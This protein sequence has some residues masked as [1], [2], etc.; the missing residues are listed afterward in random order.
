VVEPR[1][2]GDYAAGFATRRGPTVAVAIVCLA[3]ALRLPG[4]FGWW[5]NP[6]EGTYYAVLTQRSLS[7][8]WAEAFATAHP[9]LYFLILR[10]MGVI[11]TDF[12]WL[13]SLALVSGCAAVYVFVLVGRE[14]AGEGARGWLTGLAAGLLLALSPRA[15]A[16]S[17]VIRPYMLLVLLLAFTL[18]V[19]LRYFRRPSSGLLVW[20]AVSATLSAF[21]HYS[22]ALGLGVIGA[23][24][25]ADGLA[26]GS[27]RPEWRRLLAVQVFPVAAVGVLY[28]THLRQL[29]ES[30]VAEF[31]L[32]G[33]LSGYLIHTPRDAWLSL[34][35]FHSLLVGDWAAV[36]ATLLSLIAVGYAARS[37][38]WAPLVTVASG[39][40]I[41]ML[42]ASLQLYPFGSGRHSAWLVPFVTPGL[43]WII[44]KLATSDRMS[45]TLG[46]LT[47]AAIAAGVLLRSPLG[48]DLT[49]PAAREHVL[50]EEHVAAMAEV[51]D[52]RSEPRVVV[53][54]LET[55]RL[56]VPLYALERQRAQVSPDR[57]LAHFRWASRDV[58]VL[59]GLDIAVR[60]D[61]MDQPNHLY[62]A[63][64]RAASGFGVALP[65]N[66]E[67]VLVLSGGWQ[68]Q[69]IFEL[70]EM[71]RRVGLRGT[72]QSVPGLIALTLDLEAYGR[73]L[74]DLNP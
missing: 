53:M 28:V 69:G 62:T 25:L 32:T 47:V 21:V 36:S 12:A 46:T 65:E 44:A 3:L 57:F 60:P 55:Y 71:S 6:D 1:S 15:I 17:Q 29:M 9:P 54:S 10:G 7:A 56:L 51:L 30:P 20:C 16:L 50:R 11:G 31:A 64:H 70:A 22:A 61:Q 66:G 37:R 48:G 68:V 43:A 4:L 23:L 2:V 18:Y 58:I 40:L 38:A 19:L 24:V 73:A 39:L 72:T 67:P 63:T 59:P 27:A 14:M 35:G 52:P 41:A 5:L 42:C 34:V 26:R 13:R 49:E 8:F 33:W 74:A 45:W